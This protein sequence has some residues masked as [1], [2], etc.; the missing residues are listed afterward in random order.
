MIKKPT[1]KAPGKPKDDKP[2]GILPSDVRARMPRPLSRMVER[3][4]KSMLG[5]HG[6]THGAIVTKW[7]E[8]VGNDM[9]RHTQPEKI[10]F[11]RDGV[12]GGTLH[13][14]CDSGAQATEI[15]HLE[16]QILERIN[17]FFGYKAVIR[18]RLIQGPLPQS[19][20]QRPSRPPRPLSPEEAQK[21]AGTVANVDDD[22]LRQAL[23][24]LGQSIAGRNRKED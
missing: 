19:K 18:V 7:P 4:T 3:L 16:P 23:E 5:R 9:A 21:L 22:E 15:Q 24:R 10:V 11:S 1:T 14:R 2:K 12:S 17:T 8:I 20:G 13:L 6:F